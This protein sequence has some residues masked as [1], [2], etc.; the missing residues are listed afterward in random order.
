MRTRTAVSMRKE[1]ITIEQFQNAAFFEVAETDAAYLDQYGN[2]MKSPD[3]KA[4]INAST[5]DYI[6]TVGKNY[7]IVDNKEYFEGVVQALTDGGIEY[8]PKSVWVDSNGKRTTMIVTLPQFNLYKGTDEAQDFELRIRNSFDTT[9]AADTILGMIR[10]ICTNGMT[11][12]DQAFSHR[13]IHKGDIVKKAEDSIELFKDFQGVW[14]RNRDIIE[15]LG[16]SKGTRSKVEAYIG[17]GEITRQPMFTG[18]RWAAKLLTRWQEAGE[19]VNL[20][21]IYNMFTYIISHEYGSNYSSKAQKM[22][23]LNKEARKWFRLLDVK[24]ASVFN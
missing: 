21:D 23:M 8:E 4:I 5:G 24:T 7:S 1:P 15:G 18:Q 20:W 17:D 13:I 12:F 19:P 22:D 2:W 16:N 3:R 6:S 11:A 9:V 10:L 14:Q